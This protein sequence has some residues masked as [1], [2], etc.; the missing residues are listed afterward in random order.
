MWQR[1]AVHY[2]VWFEPT[3]LAYFR[4]HAASESSDLIKSGRQIADAR[5]VIEIAHSYLPCD[6]KKRL[7]T[8]AREN[9]ALYA[10]DVA[11]RQLQA[12]DYQA[13]LANI[14][15]GLQCS[16]SPPITEKLLT[17]LGQNENGL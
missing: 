14:R 15:E 1:L 6:S 9:Y 13:A 17:L 5:R 11:Q 12:A 7:S 3:P 16:R 10:L 4:E 2:P 8:K